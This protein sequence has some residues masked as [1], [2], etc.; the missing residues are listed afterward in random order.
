MRSTLPAMFTEW[1]PLEDMARPWWE[2]AYCTFPVPESWC[3]V[4]LT[5]CPNLRG[6]ATHDR[7]PWDDVALEAVGM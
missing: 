2:G 1:P 4:G 7:D 5:V 6:A 3:P